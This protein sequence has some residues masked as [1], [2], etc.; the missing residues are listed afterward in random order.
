VAAVAL[1]QKARTYFF[2][3]TRYDRVAYIKAEPILFSAIFPSRILVVHIH[4]SGF[5]VCL[6]SD[7]DTT[8][9]TF[10]TVKYLAAEGS[11]VE[12]GYLQ[13]PSLVCE[14]GSRAVLSQKFV[15]R[16]P[17]SDSGI[18]GAFNLIRLD[19]Q[20]RLALFGMPQITFRLIYRQRQNRDE[21]LRSL[22]WDVQLF[23]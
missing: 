1:V 6:P 5:K 17:L 13:N 10:G 7:A 16:P 4:L 18:G 9:Y 8:G 14:L 21:Q 12:T 23:V 2:P 3:P 22:M 11:C 19:E 15:T 20:L